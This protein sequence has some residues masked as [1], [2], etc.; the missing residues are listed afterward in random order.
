MNWTQGQRIHSLAIILVLLSAVIG[1]P[2]AYSM[3][4]IGHGLEDVASV[5]VPGLYYTGKIEATARELR[6]QVLLHGHQPTLEAKQAPEAAIRV[7]RRDL[8]TTLPEFER[9]LTSDDDRRRLAA[10]RHAYGRYVLIVDRALQLSREGKSAEL[11]TLLN[12]DCAPT[13]KQFSA[14][15]VEA[16]ESSRSAAQASVAAV[17]ETGRLA[18]NRNWALLAFTALVGAFLTQL[19]VRST[20]RMDRTV[21]EIVHQLSNGARQ[22]TSAAGSISASSQLLANTTSEQASALEQTSASSHQLSAT[23]EGNVESAREVANFM[24]V[25]DGQVN[26]ANHTLE[27]MITSM[28]EIGESSSKISRII[29][30]IENISFQTNILA[31]NVADE[32]RNLAQRSSQAAKDTAELIEESIRRSKEGNAQVGQVVTT[33]HAITESTKRVKSLIDTVHAG[34][35]EQARG[36]SQISTAAQ[37]LEQSNQ[38]SAAQAEECASA[39]EQLNAQSQTMF[40]MVSRLQELVGQGA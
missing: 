33:I 20:G 12:A 29:A 19:I 40:H 39:S 38:R 35:A 16:R 14:A 25:V 17:L 34:S 26:E 11:V 21:S 28:K 10:I 5:H 2:M 24:T 9:T 3:S 6:I 36:I 32:V 7:L 31:L 27:K 8:E 1:L 4:Q 22:V 18:T 23:T 30:V 37:Q 15:I 13:F